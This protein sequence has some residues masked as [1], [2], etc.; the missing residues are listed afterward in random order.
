MG[1]WQRPSAEH[2]FTDFTFE[3]FT[4]ASSHAWSIT[5]S[6]ISLTDLPGPQGFFHFS[7]LFFYHFFF[8]FTMVVKRSIGGES[9][10]G[11]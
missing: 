5:Y 9:A 4:Q 7:K 8:N 6:S 2:F 3:T 10:F 11:H 1:T